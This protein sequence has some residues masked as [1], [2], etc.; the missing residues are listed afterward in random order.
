MFMRCA[1]IMCFLLLFSLDWCLF[2]GGWII[3]GYKG[4]DYGVISLMGPMEL[5]GPMG[6]MGGRGIATSWLRS[7]WLWGGLMTGL[8]LGYVSVM[9][10]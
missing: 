10:G 9:S 2:E 5:M 7:G 8:C 6:L 3:V 4:V 1:N